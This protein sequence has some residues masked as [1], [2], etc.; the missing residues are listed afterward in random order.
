MDI[1][2]D[3]VHSLVQHTIDL[4]DKIIDLLAKEP[5]DLALTILMGTFIMVG[6]GLG[7]TSE[8]M[9]K[10]VAEGADIWKATKTPN[11]DKH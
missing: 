4:Q 10:S 9:S 3:K 1:D 2:D 11:K 6:D 5:P 8:Q 7:L